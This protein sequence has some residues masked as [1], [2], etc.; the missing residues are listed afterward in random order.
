LGPR[1]LR[2]TARW[3]ELGLSNYDANFWDTTLEASGQELLFHP[4]AI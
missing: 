3:G 4:T 1:S 2:M